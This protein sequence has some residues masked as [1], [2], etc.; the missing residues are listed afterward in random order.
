MTHAS[1]AT[2]LPGLSPNFWRTF[3]SRMIDVNGLSLHAV[4]G[5]RGP[6]LL[7]L[8]GWPQTWYVWRDMLPVLAQDF[9]VVAAEFRGV[10][11]SDKPKDG[12]DCGSLATDMVALMDV[13]GH[14]RFAVIGH[15]VG[16]W[17]GYALAA[18]HP[19]RIAC[20][21]VADASIPGLLP[22]PP[23]L[24]EEAVNRKLWHFAFNRLD[25]LNERLVEGREEI[26]FGYQFRSKG[27]TPDAVPPEAVKVYVDALK[28]QS[29]LRSSFELYRCIATN[30]AQNERRRATR[31]TLPVLAIGGALGLGER[32]EQQMRAAAD[33]VTG[34]NIP[35][36]GHYIPDEAPEAMLA[37]IIPFLAP[38]KAAG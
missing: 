34:V 16:M 2:S 26:F 5:G 1:P 15:D 37:A 33:N 6:P 9:S 8:N 13:L 38:Y 30:I 35:G 14:H 3:Q 32:V 21:T 25:G 12:Y 10:G 31:L 24:S 19:D 29:A 11:L 27:A 7:L 36:C 20:L 4:V 17:V 28:S 22:S 23:L 18:D